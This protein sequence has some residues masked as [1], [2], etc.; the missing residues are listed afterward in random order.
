MT[1]NGS[2]ELKSELRGLADLIAARLAA[3]GERVPATERYAFRLAEASAHALSD[4]LARLER[5]GFLAVDSRS[6]RAA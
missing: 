5:E 2:S 3:H 1:A 4:E 6:G